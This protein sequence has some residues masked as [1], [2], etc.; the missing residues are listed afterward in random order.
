MNTILNSFFALARSQLVDPHPE[1]SA[2]DYVPIGETG[3]QLTTFRTHSA[4]DPNGELLY[5]PLLVH[6]YS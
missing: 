4:P 6:P 5:E 1:A 2:S 3:V